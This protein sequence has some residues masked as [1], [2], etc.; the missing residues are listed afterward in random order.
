VAKDAA[1]NDICGT[2]NDRNWAYD[3]TPT[4]SP[5]GPTRTPT[6]TRTP[7]RI[8]AAIISQIIINEFLPHSRSDWNND[9]VIDSGDEFIELTNVGNA[10]GNL[11][12]WRLDDQDGDSSPYT[13]GDIN[14]APGA[15]VIFFASETGLLLSNRSDSVRVFKANGVISD[16][17]TYTTVPIPDQTWCRLPDGKPTWIFGCQP[18][19]SQ[20]NQPA[21]TIYRGEVDMPAIC[22]SPD[23]PVSIYL[24]ECVP[25]GLESWSRRLWDDLQPVFRVLVERHGQEYWIE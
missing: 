15:R 22:E 3:V 1:D 20:I 9:G 11:E 23:L 18:T 2:P 16:A 7:T 21:E 12:G 24:A 8:P 19:L 25:S 17:F 5:V 6:K 13:L 14:L 10:S 4:P